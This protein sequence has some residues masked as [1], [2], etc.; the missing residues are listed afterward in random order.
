MKKYVIVFKTKDGE[1]RKYRSQPVRNEIYADAAWRFYCIKNKIVF[2]ER[3]SIE[4]VKP[5]R[6][7]VPEGVSGRLNF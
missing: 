3:I 5:R 7:W 1:V 4:E 6:I 2:P